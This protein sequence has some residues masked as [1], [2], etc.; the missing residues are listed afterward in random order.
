MTNAEECPFK[1]L[2]TLDN[3]KGKD[4]AVVNQQFPGG[5][6][7]FPKLPTRIDGDSRTKLFVY[8]VGNDT[9]CWFDVVVKSKKLN[10]NV[11]FHFLLLFL[12]RF[13]HYLWECA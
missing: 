12:L 11:Y 9:G 4:Y 8:F 3:D 13:Y 5:Y 7:F 10:F 1:G 2:L 6:N